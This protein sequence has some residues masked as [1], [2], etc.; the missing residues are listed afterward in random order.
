MYTLAVE[1]GEIT[2]NPVSLVRKPRQG[3]VGAVQALDPAT[4]ERIRRHMVAA[5]DLFSATLV[6]VLAYSGVRPGEAP[7][8]D[9][10]VRDR[11]PAQTCRPWPAPTKLSGGEGSPYATVSELDE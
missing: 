2:N 7:L 8:V 1:W 10:R 6:S 3:R 11:S 9:H 5:G 4:V